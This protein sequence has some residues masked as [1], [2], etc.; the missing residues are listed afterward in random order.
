MPVAAGITPNVT[1]SSGTLTAETVGSGVFQ[2]IVCDDPLDPTASAGKYLQV[3]AECWCDDPTVSQGVTTG[4]I[5][6][7]IM[8]KVGGV[9]N[10]Y[11]LT[12]N[13]WQRG[14]FTPRTAWIKLPGDSPGITWHLMIGTRAQ[15]GYKCKVR[16]ISASVTDAVID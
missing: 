2:Y 15:L 6:F 8:A 16:N 3:N 13:L 7:G 14:D 10:G 4:G 1:V 5:R 12:N 11:P 9:Y